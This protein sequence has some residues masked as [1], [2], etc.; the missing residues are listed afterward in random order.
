[1]ERSW[2]AEG[3]ARRV[4][5]NIKQRKRRSEGEGDEEKKIRR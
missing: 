1:M 3:V 2:V 4:E 5:G